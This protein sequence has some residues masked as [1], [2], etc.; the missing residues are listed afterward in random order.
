L[1]FFGFGSAVANLQLLLRGNRSSAISDDP[2]PLSTQPRLATSVSRVRYLDGLRGLAAIQVIIHHYSVGFLNDSNHLGFIGNGN[3]AVYIFFLMSG[4]VLTFSFEKDPLGLSRNLSRRLIRLGLPVTVAALF[5]TCL[6]ATMYE[7]GQQA[8][9]VSGSKLLSDYSVFPSLRD[10]VTE[11]SG[12]RMLTG[13]YETTIFRE[14][15]PYLPIMQRAVDP[16]MWTLHIELW[17]SILVILLVYFHAKSPSLYPWIVLLTL[18]G[19]GGHPLGLFV[20][21][22]FTAIYFD[23]I[24]KRILNNWLSFIVGSLVLAA[25]IYLAAAAAPPAIWRLT[26]LLNISIFHMPFVNLKDEIGAVM[27]FVATMFIAPIRYVLRCGTFVWLGRMSF[28]L[29]LVHFPIMITIGSI[30]FLSLVFYIDVT[31]AAAVTFC[32]GMI[33]T[34]IVAFLFEKYVDYPAI[35]LSRRVTAPLRLNTA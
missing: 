28:S 31:G 16:P 27:V 1:I 6:L 17:G 11:A 30:V 34:M 20:V 21:G 3:F 32:V 35:L 26:P 19:T 4:Y 18:I 8:A 12:L 7:F 25:G 29:Y 22:N 9:V 15:A 23:R 33:T 13:F 14:I 5:A 2:I 24:P 10:V